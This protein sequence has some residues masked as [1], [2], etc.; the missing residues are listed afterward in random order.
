M[1][2]KFPAGEQRLVGLIR[3]SVIPTL[4]SHSVLEAPFCNFMRVNLN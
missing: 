1:E 2:V 4:E 3:L